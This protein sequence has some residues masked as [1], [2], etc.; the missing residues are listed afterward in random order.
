MAALGSMVGPALEAAKILVEEKFSVTVIN[1]RFVK[2]LD[3]KLLAHYAREAD[4]FVTVEEGIVNGGFGSAVLE[5]FST[6]GIK[7]LQLLLGLPDIFIEHGQ[8]Q[9][10]LAKYNLTAAGIAEQIKKF[11]QEK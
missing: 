7:T 6:K 8:R 2:P 4:C 10:I 5:L 1:A 3:E 9:E 11:S